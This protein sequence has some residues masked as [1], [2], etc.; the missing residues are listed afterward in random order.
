M[1]EEVVGDL[2]DLALLQR[3]AHRSLN[4]QRFSLREYPVELY[5]DRLR[6]DVRLAKVL[7][8][9]STLQESLAIAP[10]A[11]APS[12]ERSTHRA[13]SSKRRS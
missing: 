4:G 6:A 3:G 10:T 11:S 12:Y 1:G 13:G 5:E 2:V 7:R 9:E 8:V